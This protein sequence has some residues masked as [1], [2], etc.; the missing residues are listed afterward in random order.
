MADSGTDSFVGVILVL[1][2]VVAVIASVNGDPL[3]P[4]SS[5]SSTPTSTPTA[6]TLRTSTAAST[7]TNIPG[8]P[9]FACGGDVIANRSAGRGTAAVGLRVYYSTTAGGRNC[10]VAT[11]ADTLNRRKG[12]LSITLRFASYDGTSWP[13][14][15]RHRSSPNALRSGAV[16]LDDT[17]DRCVVA[18]AVFTPADGGKPTTVSTGRVG[19]D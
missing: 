5:P 7:S 14:L 16:Y 18:R 6:R 17:D 2:A 4:T 1:V 11:R 9:L 12:Q 8:G 10:A 13:R 19:C 3:A 15:A